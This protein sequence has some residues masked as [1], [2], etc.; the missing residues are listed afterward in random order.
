MDLAVQRPDE[1]VRNSVG[2]SRFALEV[3][4]YDFA[5]PGVGCPGTVVTATATATT[6]TAATAAETSGL[7]VSTTVAVPSTTVSSAAQECHTH[8]DGSVHC[9]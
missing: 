2:L 8:G 7:V 4:A 9:A 5:V 6:T 3:W 1:A